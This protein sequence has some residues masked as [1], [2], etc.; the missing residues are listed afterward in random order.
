MIDRLF[1]LSNTRGK[2]SVEDRKTITNGL[3][4]DDGSVAENR[5]T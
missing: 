3:A 2:D 5:R 1:S 4:T